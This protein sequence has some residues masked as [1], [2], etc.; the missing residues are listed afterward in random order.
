M[1]TKIKSTHPI[2]LND[3]D[4]ISK[5][6]EIFKTCDQS[7]NLMISICNVEKNN[8]VYCNKMLQQKIGKHSTAL[9]QKGWDFWFSIID[10]N[11]SSR[12]KNKIVDFFSSA[13]DQQLLSLKY[14]ITNFFKE[15]I[16]MKHEILLFTIE[17]EILALNY[18][19]DVSEKEK[20]ERCLNFKKVDKKCVL[21]K[22]TETYISSREEQVLKLIA[23]GFS[24]KQIADKL[25][26]SNHTAVSHRKH[27]IEKFEVKNTAHLIKKASKIIEL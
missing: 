16:C 5:F 9:L 7:R 26:I 2:S 23:D 13:K 10:S 25:F 8:F 22:R 21:S 15:R 11:E 3:P 14:H 4:F 6:S 19:F 24:S 27:L 20:I 17:G 12:I 1:N 18:Y